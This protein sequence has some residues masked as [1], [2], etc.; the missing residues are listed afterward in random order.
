MN[1]IFFLP[2]LCMTLMLSACSFPKL[3]IFDTTPNPLQEHTLE[4]TGKDNYYRAAAPDAAN[5]SL[6]NVVLPEIFNIRSGLYCL[7]PGAID[8]E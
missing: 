5:I 7:W 8:F 4:G 3:N 6:I 2:T 1:K